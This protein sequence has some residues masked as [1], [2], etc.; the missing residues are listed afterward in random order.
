MQLTD[1]DCKPKG[2]ERC[3]FRIQ[4]L[5]VGLMGTVRLR[6]DSGLKAGVISA[7]TM[8]MAVVGAGRSIGV[9]EPSAD[10]ASDCA[11]P[12]L[13][14]GS[15]SLPTLESRRPLDKISSS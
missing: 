4:P 7:S 10:I 13:L 15:S 3:C 1:L 14:T 11:A 2:N 9:I 12:V 5:N 6:A 8:L